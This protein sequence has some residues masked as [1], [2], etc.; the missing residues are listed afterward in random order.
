MNLRPE[1]VNNN[2]KA[3][4]Y[5]WS[6]VLLGVFALAKSQPGLLQLGFLEWAQLAGL[7]TIVFI[8]GLFPVRIPG[9]YCVI[10][11]SDIFIF[12]TCLWL[13]IPAATLVAVLDS[14]VASY[15]ASTRWSTR[16][17][18][19][20][21]SAFTM[22]ASATLFQWLMRVL[23]ASLH[24]NRLRLFVALLGFA[25]CYFLLS[26][27]LMAAFSALKQG[28]PF[29]HSWWSN[30]SWIGVTYL[31]SASC[32][33][34]IYLSLEIYGIVALLATGPIVSVIFMTFYLYFKQAEERE[35]RHL[36]HIEAV[37]QQAA[38][39][40]KHLQDL[41]ESEERF[42]NA[43]DYAAIGMALLSTQGNWLQV[44]LSLCQILGYEE[45]ELLAK[46][47]PRLLHPDDA[48][49]VE[50]A[51][52]QLLSSQVPAVQIE[53]RFLN[54][55]EDIVWVS[56]HASL[57][58]ATQTQPQKLIFQ[59][60]NITDRKRAEERLLHDAFH[61]SLTGLPNRALL[62]DHLS[63]AMARYKRHSER[64]FA[65]LFLDVD[66]FKIINDSLGHLAGDELLIEIAKRLERCIRPGD[67]I[68]R[69]GGDEFT[70]LLEELHH[71]DEVMP[72]AE[73]IQKAIMNPI[74][75]NATEVTITVSMGIAFSSIGYQQPEE[76]LR[77]AD[78][79]MYQAKSSGKARY[80]LFAPGMHARAIRQL[81]IE[82]DLRRALDRQE[83]FLV[84]QPIVSIETSKLVGFEALV[85]WQHP[86]H[87][88]ISPA[89][90]IPVAEETGLIIPLGKW[91]LSEACRQLR[92]WQEQLSIE[93]PAYL[94]MS[95]NLSG[96]QLMQDAIVEEVCQT[97]NQY[98]IEPHHLKLEITE[99]VVMENIEVA[100]RKLNQLREFG[101]RMSIDDFGTGYSSLSY[102][103]R[104]PTQTLK[105]DRSFVQNMTHSNDHAEIVRTIVTLAR[106]LKMEVTAEGIE[107]VD[108]LEMLRNLSCE[109]GQGFLFSK[110][111]PAE[112]AM[113]QLQERLR[114]PAQN[115]S[116]SVQGS[117]KYLEIRSQQHAT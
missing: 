32:A 8:A 68:A 89:E 19:T 62:L 46:D 81:Q 31:A 51:L 72:L 58:G 107:T 94:T 106:T 7:A 86:G 90:F 50:R 56:L 55:S 109:Y 14:F 52:A 85:R 79:A 45:T 66:R 80:A 97:L 5:W 77:D 3:N 39:A 28:R 26:S 108:Q 98:Q 93:L 71:P 96:K 73:R 70:I 11:P 67:T 22:F 12:L 78:T 87:G 84:Y 40:E 1:A 104:L 74:K 92:A 53:I 105:V 10:T 82:N 116:S 65:V 103:H 18:S 9:T 25:L 48:E 60:Q 88:L 95:V 117:E 101:V 47:F 36:Q 44:N 17:A 59:I 30:Y 4:I 64:H 37:E 49:V 16:I 63:L 114:Q 35:K 23:P 113:E 42:R 6:I 61:D 33:G 2:S 69:L 91:V 41:Q 112:A 27:F 54:A 75:L 76:L 43:F 34:L 24:H 115:Q 29:F 21:I 57:I 100:I 99:S 13:G 15:R 102:L 38:L 110:P 111:L 20:S 83:F